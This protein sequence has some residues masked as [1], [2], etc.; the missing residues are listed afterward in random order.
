MG[1]VLCLTATAVNMNPWINPLV[2]T[3]DCVV[4]DPSNVDTL[5]LCF[6]SL[7]YEADMSTTPTTPGHDLVRFGDVGPLWTVNC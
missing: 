1:V 7:G 3:G 2:E 4:S 6:Q 5:V